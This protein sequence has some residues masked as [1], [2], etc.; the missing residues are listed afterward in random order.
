MKNSEK[1][2]L[3]EE[4]IKLLEEIIELKGREIRAEKWGNGAVPIPV[5][6]PQ[7]IPYQPYQMA[8][9]TGDPLPLRS[10]TIC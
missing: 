9:G 4:K 6:R 3:L 5:I 1:I 10:R 7:I 8:L 2:R